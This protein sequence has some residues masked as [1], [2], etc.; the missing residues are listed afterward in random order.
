MADGVDHEKLVE[1][2]IFW[3]KIRLYGLIA[4]ISL[5]VLSQLTQMGFLIYLRVAAWAVASYAAYREGS[6][7]K[8]AG[9]DDENRILQSVLYAVVALMILFM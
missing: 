3:G 4:A 6:A 1:E 2:S 5:L 9:K 8:K 7:L